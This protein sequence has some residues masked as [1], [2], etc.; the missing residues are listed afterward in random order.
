MYVYIYI[1]IYI[2]GSL[3]IVSA[4]PIFYSNL[5]TMIQNDTLLCDLIY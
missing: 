3:S 5:L 1:Y 2:L 4:D